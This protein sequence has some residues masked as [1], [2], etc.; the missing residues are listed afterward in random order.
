MKIEI[1]ETVEKT[2]I[3]D[4]DLPYY[5]RH[6][7]DNCTIYGKIEETKRT[8]IDVYDSEQKFEMEVKYHYSIKNSGLS[9]YFAEEHKSSEKEYIEAREKAK[10][11]LENEI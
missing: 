5:Y 2:K 6:L 1:I 4:A 8:T 3:I 9:S 7:L 11:F 10:K